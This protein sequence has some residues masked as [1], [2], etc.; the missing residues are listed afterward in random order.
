MKH[1]Q[2]KQYKLRFLDDENHEKLKLKAEKE[3][4]S[5]NWLINQAIK[6]F[7]NQE[8]AKA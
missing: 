7:L 8:S 5:I 6:Q 4:R 2:N 1:Q 3:E